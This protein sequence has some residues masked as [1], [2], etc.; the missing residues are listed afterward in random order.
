[1]PRGAGR[2]VTIHDAMKTLDDWRAHCERLHPQ[3]IELGLERVRT[4][5]RLP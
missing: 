5:V 1:M 2:S 3:T 4:V